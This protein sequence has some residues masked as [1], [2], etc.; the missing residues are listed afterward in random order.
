MV[1]IKLMQRDNL[2]IFKCLLLTKKAYHHILRKRKQERI[3]DLVKEVCKEKHCHFLGI[4]VEDS[5]VY[6]LIGIAAR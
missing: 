2:N 3:H 1:R 6:A 5:Y 4:R